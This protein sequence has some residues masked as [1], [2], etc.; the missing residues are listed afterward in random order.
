[1]D[2]M[3]I[4]KLKALGLSGSSRS[5]PV[6]DLKW[7]KYELNRLT[8]QLTLD[9]DNLERQLEEARDIN[10]VLLKNHGRDIGLLYGDLWMYRND[11][12]MHRVLSIIIEQLKEKGDE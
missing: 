10:K 12:K 5:C 6:E 3:T 11:P 9:F 4:N 7:T 2:N 8:E 1:M